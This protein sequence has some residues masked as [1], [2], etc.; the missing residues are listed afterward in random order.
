MQGV[1]EEAM[2]MAM[3]FR[4]ALIGASPCEIEPNDPPSALLPTPLEVTLYL[5]RKY[6]L[7][8][9]LPFRCR[10]SPEYLMHSRRGF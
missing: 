1:A 2:G 5:V 8:L 9:L 3:V 10:Q 6:S 7:L 4:T